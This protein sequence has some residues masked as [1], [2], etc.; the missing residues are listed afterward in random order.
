MIKLVSFRPGVIG[1]NTAF[2]AQ[3]SIYKYL[4]KHYG[5]R[6]TI[7]KSE[8]DQYHDPAFEIISIPQ[9]AWK[10]RL[11]KL[12]IPKLGAIHK[13]LEP[14][15]VQADGILTVDPTTYLQGLL[16]IRIAHQLKK[17]VW[18]DA[19]KTFDRTPK[20]LYFQWKRRFWLRKALHQTTGIIVTVP[21]CI[22]RFQELGLFD[23]VIAPKFRILGHPVDT[24]RFTPKPKRSEKDG[25]LRV[26][27]VSRMEPEKGLLYILEAMTP[28]LRS[29]RNLQLELLG[30]GAMRSLLEAEVTERGLSDQ[31][32]FLN[33]VSHGEIHDILAGVD[34]FVNHAVSI[35]SW[36][37]YFGV[38]NLEAMSCG[39]PCVLTSCGG[40]SYAVRE[41]D[42]AVFVEERNV[43]QLREAIIHLLDSQQRQEMGKKGRDYVEAYYGLI[44]IA[45]K[46][47]RMLQHSLVEDGLV[48]TNCEY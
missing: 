40:I 48:L 16:A 36:E 25:I 46:F 8:G 45:E 43:I 32:I 19:S 24:Q 7:V 5:Y 35:G 39:L 38:V 22:E 44:V 33:S 1:N 20:N 30:S 28:L 37:E 18:F 26:L 31:V 14:I 12:G 4:Q 6:F 34:V 17:P 11:Q 15:F 10:S 29:R 23:Q 42:V 21:K 13:S 47:H 2:E 3:A 27:V 9:T 41:K